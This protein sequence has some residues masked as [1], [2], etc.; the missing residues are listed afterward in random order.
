MQDQKAWKMLLSKLRPVSESLQISVKSNLSNWRNYVIV[1]L[2]LMIIFSGKSPLSFLNFST[3][4]P[5]VKTEY[6]QVKLPESRLQL[7]DI[8][9][10]KPV[11]GK[12]VTKGL[13]EA[14]MERGEEIERC[15]IDK[16]YLREL[17]DK[18]L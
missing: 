4:P 7:H 6:I 12:Y 18:R 1:A 3:P 16:K 14:Y 8:P 13:V 17:G 11:G 10:V 5:I 2:L 9:E 15:N